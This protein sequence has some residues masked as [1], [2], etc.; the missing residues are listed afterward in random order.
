[1]E[2]TICNEPYV[3]YVM[4]HLM[5]GWFWFDFGL[6]LAWIAAALTCMV[7]AALTCIDFH[8]FALISI[9]CH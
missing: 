6:A 8:C 4:Y 3:H 1:M 2:C 5:T 9:D 7:A